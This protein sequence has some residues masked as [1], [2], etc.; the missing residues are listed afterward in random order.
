[1]YVSENV[2]HKHEVDPEYLDT[3]MGYRWSNEASDIIVTGI[4]MLVQRSSSEMFLMEVQ[5]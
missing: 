5:N 3:A 2:E 4:K 1:M